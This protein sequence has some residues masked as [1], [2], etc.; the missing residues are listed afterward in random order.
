MKNLA[1][2]CI[3]LCMFFCMLLSGFTAA[4][5]NTKLHITTDKEKYNTAE[6]I[7]FQVFLLNPSAN[8]NNTLFVELL[9]CNGKRLAKQMLPFD[10]NVS[11]GHFTLP[12][13]AK[14]EF[15]LLYCYVNNADSMECSSIK[16]VFL[17]SNSAS[18]QKQTENKINVSSFFEGGT[19]V[20]ESPNNILVQCTDEN[21]NPVITKGKITNGK[22]N[23]YAVFETNE[24]GFAKVSLNPEDKVRYY[25]EVKDKSNNEGLGFVPIAATSGITLNTTVT[26]NSII[27]NLVSYTFLNE[28]IPDYRI[29]ALYNGQIVYD[30]AIS[31]QNG[32][33][34][35][36]QELTKEELLK[37]EKF[38]TAGF[39]TFR[40]TD[41]T[42][43][44]YA[45][46]VV[47]YS[48]KPAQNNFISVI[49]TVNKREATISLPDMVSGKASI[50]IRAADPTSALKS[51][52]NFLTIAAEI[53]I[54]DQL[55]A[56]ANEP[57]GFNALNNET[58][59]YLSLS[60]ILQNSEKKPLKNKNVNIILQQKNFKKQYLVTK[61][62]NTGRLQ[63]DNLVFFDTVTVYY[64]L[65]DKSE[66]KNDVSLDLKVT[67]SK[68]YTGK[69][70]PPLNLFCS[71][72]LKGAD[73]IKS[74]EKIL[75][76]VIV[77]ADKEKT[78]S[79][80]FTDR[81]VSGQMK[82]SQ[83]TRNE[84]DFIKNP[85][86]IDNR[87]LF[88][89]I[90]GRIPNIRVFIDFMGTPVL[91]GTNGG[92][93]GVYLN[94]MDIESNLNQ[95]SGIQIKDVALIK[96]HSISL[97]PKN[98]LKN[99]LVDVKGG[100]AGDLL[101]YT[102][103]DFSPNEEKTK[104]LPKTS[105]VGYTLERKDYD[106]SLLTDETGPLFWKPDWNVESGQRIF[107]H[108]P[109]GGLKEDVEIIIEGINALS[110]PYRFTQKLV[111][112]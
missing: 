29:E 67:P 68:E 81:Y 11:S 108:V 44:I 34:A 12:E 28:R 102:K 22:G 45:Q 65:A 61:T 48:F 97:K 14:A 101:I 15:Y 1:N 63:V 19:F 9:D 31:F 56:T 3:S 112:K 4:A 37:I 78:N 41:K 107:V 2:H 70:Q 83:G 84:Y 87:S 6:I 99:E 20:A 26:Q 21:L 47:Y 58:N 74:D 60:G 111:F 96:Y 13:T 62:D 109:A 64:Q 18:P 77:T 94:D 57:S 43:K 51:D 82:R 59:R 98:G 73:S 8:I 40:L 90:K 79:E 46:R 10:L 76:Q 105:V 50:Q 75:K 93:V 104:G 92:T 72:Y 39:I 95:L 16:K 25:I 7:Q 30:A 55:I 86:E 89:F 52:L 33:S 100:D 53:P 38:P 91:R 32:L 36:K 103:Q 35:V 110:A 69:A 5:G 24:L 42:N 106:P 71:A 49:D 27:Y 17:K 85:E 88:D 54:N 23:I 66:E 80:K